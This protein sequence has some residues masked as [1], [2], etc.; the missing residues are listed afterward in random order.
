MIEILT[1]GAFVASFIFGPLLCALAL[2]LPARPL[3][4]LVLGA[5]VV[6]AVSAALR[7][8]QGSAVPSLIALWLAWVLAVSMVAL[9]LSR[10]LSAPRARRWLTVIAL[11]TTTLPW[12]GLATARLMV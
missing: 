11:L 1:I 6:A 3:S 8:Q 5:G 12:F 7:L 4:L 10:R 2:S 9:A